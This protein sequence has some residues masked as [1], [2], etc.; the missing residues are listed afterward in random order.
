MAAVTSTAEAVQGCSVEPLGAMRY[1]AVCTP[2]FRSD[3]ALAPGDHA[4]LA[5]AP[6]IDFDR[7][8]DL[9]ATLV[10]RVAD[11][12]VAT[13]QAR[14]FIP[15]SSDFARAVV[16]GFGWGMLPEQQCGVE[17]EEGKLVEVAPGQ[18]TEVRLFWQRW[19]LASPLLDAVTDAVRAGAK[20]SL[21]GFD[22]S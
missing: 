21:R 2:G 11:S 13:A 14:H 15:T 10:R 7:R 20:A 5:R 19:N 1:R 4:A 16:L 9:Q 17:L 12:G 8:D 3:H 22:G 18:Y 6:R